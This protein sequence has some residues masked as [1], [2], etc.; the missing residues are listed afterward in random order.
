LA[1]VILTCVLEIHTR[2]TDHQAL[3]AQKV[4]IAARVDELL[5]VVVIHRCGQPDARRSIADKLCRAPRI[6]AL[7]DAE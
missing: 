2:A 1:C 4:S 5:A 3:N 7:V 6:R